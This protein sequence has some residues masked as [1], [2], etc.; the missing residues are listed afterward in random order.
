MTS[1]AFHT[2]LHRLI[3]LSAVVLVAA[4]ASGLVAEAG[5]EQSSEPTLPA[6]G[7]VDAGGFHSCAVL[8][9]GSVRCWGFAADGQLGYGN[10][11]TI[12]DDETPAAAGPVN[13]GVGRTAAAIATGDAHTCALL[14]DRSVRCW[15]FGGDG[16]LG[17]A[18]TVSVGG[19]EAP[20][21]VGP[22]DLGG[23]AKAISAGAAHTCAVLVDG[24]VRCWGFGGTEPDGVYM[25]D[26]RLG[27]GNRN[28]I[29]DNETPG[30]VGPVNLG[31]LK[32]VAISAGGAHTCALLEG[33]SVSCWGDG[34]SGQLGYGNANNV[35]D[36][37]TTTPDLV[38]P[39]NLGG[40]KAVAISAGGAHTCAL[41]EGGSVR[42]W[43]DGNSGQLGYGTTSNAGD[44]P[45]TTP[46]KVGPVNLGGHTAKAISAGGAHT[47]AILEDGS[48]RCWGRGASGRLGYGN[49][50]NI[51]DNETPGSVGPVDLGTGRTAVAI[52]A[53]KF[54]TCAR[55]DDGNV[56]CWGF[57]ATGRLGYCNTNTI[58]DDEL[59]GSA[60]P[61]QLEAGDGNPGC[62][63]VSPA[64]A[65]SLPLVPGAG[66]ITPPPSGGALAGDGL[67]EQ[68]RRAAAL[69]RCLDGVSRRARRQR[70]R[71]RQLTAGPRAVRFRQIERRAAHDR[72]RCLHR[73]G[74]TP[75]R[76]SAVH[77]RA[78]G[79]HTITLSFDAAGTDHE[80]PPAAR[81]YLIRQS[82]QPIRTARDFRTSHA[83]CHGSCAFNVVK[84]GATIVQRV[85]GLDRRR[86]Y[87]YAIEARDNVSKRPGPRSPTIQARTP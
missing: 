39:V 8:V 10:T 27:Y 11:V 71:A 61:I 75:G 70:H 43:G 76:V 31:G 13:L 21:S 15:G 3:A 33:G 82:T 16:R 83:L 19:N 77:A 7:G 9:V 50:E 53:G 87:Y 49:Q 29:G 1:A 5:A 66:A 72:G 62:P 52:S 68:Q 47:C 45:A 26:G 59:P 36:T 73:Y 23:P 12:G 80:R 22:V 74:R 2:D 46:D 41:L 56:R 32:A 24:S 55:L 18:N 51:G 17:Y 60:G 44:T 40:L 78:T 64:S 34:H 37:P 57:G 79:P 4:G 84:V 67:A 42:C 85:T 20:G 28:N 86:T 25:P 65:P 35:G 58:G 48:V 54:H 14:D 38:G 81:R 63:G 6:A 30:S 69:H